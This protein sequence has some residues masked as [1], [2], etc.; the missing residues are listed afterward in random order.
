MSGEGGGPGA[1]R[2]EDVWE[3]TNVRVGGHRVGHS[4]HILVI[5]DDSRG[6]ARALTEDMALAFPNLCLD[7]IDGPEDLSHYDSTLKADDHVVL[8]LVTSEVDDIDAALDTAAERPILAPTH[9]LV[10]TD[11]P[12]HS[13]L[14]RS[15]TSGR[16]ASVVSVPWTVDLLIGQSYSTMV[17]HLQA[18][19]RNPAEILGLIG[20]APPNAVQG[21]LLEGLDLPEDK[22]VRLLLEGVERVL[23]RRPRLVIPTG[24]ELAVQGEPVRA[25][26]LVLAG[27]VSLHRDG[28]RGEVLAHHASSGPL[29]GLVSLARGEKAFFTAVTTSTA[30]VVRLTNEQLEIALLQ[31][32]ALA[33]PLAA[34]AIQ[35]LTRRLM[36]AEDLHLENAILAADLEAQRE[37]LEKA[38][39]DLRA[40]R[41][42]LVEKTRFA[43]LGE[44]SAGIA[45][46]LNNPVTALARA[47]EHLGSDVDRVLAAA[48]SLEAARDA[49]HRALG[50]APRSTSQERELVKLLLPEVGGD[51]RLARRLVLAGVEDPARARGLA[52]AGEATIDV[53]ESGARIGSS[54]RSVL[55]ASERVIDLTRS[56]KGYAR[57][58]AAELQAVDVS[59]GIDDVLRLTGYRLRGVEVIREGGPTAPVLAHPAKLQQV[60][61]NLIVNAAE[62]IEDEREDV[63]KRRETGEDA[64]PARGDAPARITIR[65]AEEAEPAAPGPGVAG[66]EAPGGGGAGRED[67][68]EEGRWVLI[69]IEDNGPGIAPEIIQKIFEPHFTTKA[70]RVRYGLGMG[71]SI[72]H[73]I[74]SDH[75]GRLTVES[76][77]GR[78]RMIVRLPAMTRENTPKEETR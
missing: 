24:T 19:G 69:T 26:H 9:W 28:L 1:A 41:E 46:E 5:G 15:T 71:M 22:V 70:G 76:Q 13:D 10:V 31:E 18:E 61:T 77:P 32:P 66:P 63:D 51:R 2:R 43:M 34:L 38:L 72:V 58:D 47:A 29:I 37:A 67:R 57:P 68:G 12:T 44:L 7:R 23:G 35:S 20:Q 60:W 48:S 11:E 73:S 78:T 14:A 30:R 6:L 17:R 56:L 49:M 65:L 25:V 3:K 4:V 42:Q 36:R 40:T 74:I 50:S 27:D 33:S 39:D 8:G 16:L 75:S 53:L 21:P 45:H 62:A 59:A 54:L 52:A 55:A 64:A